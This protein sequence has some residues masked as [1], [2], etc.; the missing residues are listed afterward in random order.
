MTEEIKVVPVS[1]E[2]K[3]EQK[4]DPRLQQVVQ[5]N[6]PVLTI[7]ILDN[8]NRTLVQILALLKHKDLEKK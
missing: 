6:I 2:A 1:E 3:A 7:Q 4:V 5:G 8:I